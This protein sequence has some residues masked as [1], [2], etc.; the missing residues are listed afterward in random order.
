MSVVA[1]I[2]YV[3]GLRSRELRLDTPEDLVPRDGE[4]VWIGLVEPEAAELVTLQKVFGLHPL[5]VE[6][7]LHARQMPKVNLYGDELFVV[8]KTAQLVE[9]RIEYG[10]TDIFVGPNHLITV[11]HG[12]ARAHTE[13][14]QHLEA[15]PR[16]LAHGGDYVLHAV[17]DFIVDGYLPIVDAIDDEMA[18]MERR[19]LDAFLSR[20]EVARIF[21]LRRELMRF[22]K[23]LGPMEQVASELEHH[24]M[25][26]IDAEVK[27][28]FRDV[29]D[30]IARVASLVEGLRDVLTSVF[31]VSS[32]LEQQRQGVITRQLAA[33]AAMLA[34]PTAIAGI[35]GMNFEHMPE[36]SWTYGY[37][38][39]LGVIVG[40]CLLLYWRFKRARWL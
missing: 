40:V 33:W 30:H 12:S 39:A 22:R 26:C 31:E 8:A 5:A 24:E 3:D 16:L 2:A 37:P 9:G 23:L 18:E 6:D 35:Y 19:A 27:P 32:L 36:L 7:A 11:R 25:P 38:V 15:T 13:L 17:L 1:A 28:Y 34:V 20:N 14:R 21:T 29:R 10:E 4:F